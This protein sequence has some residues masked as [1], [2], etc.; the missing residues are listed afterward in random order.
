M[1]AVFTQSHITH[2]PYLCPQ[3]YPMKLLLRV[4]LLF[5]LLGGGFTT[6]LA[7]N[8]SDT[9]GV[10]GSIDSVWING[11][12][13]CYTFDDGTNTQTVCNDYPGDANV[14]VLQDDDG[15]QYVIT[16]Y[17]EPSSVSGPH[18]YLTYL[19]DNLA[20]NDSLQVTFSAASTQRFGFDK[21]EHVEWILNYEP[22]R[23][24]DSTNY[25]VPWKSIGKGQTDVVEAHVDFAGF[26]QSRLSFKDKN[27]N[28][29]DHAGSGGTYTV[30]VPSD[31]QCVYAWYMD[32]KLGKLNVVEL[33]TLSRRMVVV[34][35][36]GATM[37]AASLQSELNAIYAQANVS[38][39]VS[40]AA[41]FSFDL[42]S[43]GL[44]AADATLFSKYS[45]EMRA[46]RDSFRTQDTAYDKNAY[47][48]FIVPNFSD[49]AQFG[50]MVRGR[51]VGFLTAGANA[52]EAAHELGH[53]AFGLEHSFPKPAQGATTNLMDYST[54]TRLHKKQWE[55]IHSNMPVFNWLDEEED[56][57]GFYAEIAETFLSED[58]TT[59]DF[60]TNATL[61]HSKFK[62]DFIFD[63][64][65]K[66]FNPQNGSFIDKKDIK[67]QAIFYVKSGKL[68]GFYDIVAFC[69]VRNDLNK[70]ALTE[71]DIKTYNI[72]K[73]TAYRMIESQFDKT[74]FTE[75]LNDIDLVSWQENTYS[76]T[77]KLS[78][79]QEI[80]DEFVNSVNQQKTNTSLIKTGWLSNELNDKL[81]CYNEFN[82]KKFIVV[83]AKVNA[84]TFDQKDW[85]KLAEKVFYK[86]NLTSD[87][88]LITIPYSELEAIENTN[89]VRNFMPGIWFGDET[90][91]S[92]SNLRDDYTHIQKSPKD[93]L[94]DNVVIESFI[95]DVL[96]YTTKKKCTR[97]Y[98]INYRG[99]IVEEVK[100]EL[101][102][103]YYGSIELILLYDKRFELYAKIISGIEI[104]KNQYGESTNLNDAR[105]SLINFEKNHPN[106]EFQIVD[107]GLKEA[108]A[109]SNQSVCNQYVKWFRDR[110]YTIDSFNHK[111]FKTESPADEY[112][113][114]GMNKVIYNENLALID[115]VGLLLAPFG[116]DIVTDFAGSIY[117]GYYGDITQS[118]LYS[119]GVFMPFISGGMITEGRHL[120]KQLITGEAELVKSADGYLI[121]MIAKNGDEV[122]HFARIIITKNLE[123]LNGVKAFRMSKGF[124]SEK[125]IV[126]GRNMD[127]V[128][129]YKQGLESKGLKVE[130]FD[131]DVIPQ[132]AI[133]EFADFKNRGIWVNEADLPNTIMYNANKEWVE[134]M[135]AEGYDIYDIG[136]L[137][138]LA[139]DGLADGWYSAFYEMERSIVFP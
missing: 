92:L 31:A 81:I 63:P 4:L 77:Y 19:G 8:F 94:G 5:L 44:E 88:V 36:N 74:F 27:G 75:T 115:A 87:A 47:Y 52:R 61:Y 30:T 69:K 24:S 43:D 76:S 25:F 14:V 132:A 41:P 37:S 85:S 100:N 32:L 58:L 22:I 97:L 122:S 126:I 71:N 51:A 136:N 3:T 121:R 110:L 133:D 33:D 62:Y 123:T 1:D 20:G 60:S 45:P 49:P 7:Q 114:I 56:G 111:S 42:G 13:Y 118:S 137:H 138:A 102:S 113:L 80:I 83:W 95:K 15:N 50:Y 64:A 117:A 98:S 91:I 127:D 128:R 116:F 134:Q 79:D 66:N 86:S 10:P 131:G 139:G 53:G 107:H 135:V 101:S 65:V 18:N 9:L 16:I 29:L 34:P 11:N 26:D 55:T 124:N 68:C 12:E 130:I 59:N 109:L 73:Y 35:V 70:Q 112:F 38:W 119:A 78:E 106:A 28:A 99:D 40:T 6:V 2:F 17:P 93:D 108:N 104:V 120:I 129:L 46:L 105:N 72:K 90:C 125:V 54:G 82:K 48:L 84:M 96:K 89:V 23:L 67:Y 21:K 57:S 103:D 39:T